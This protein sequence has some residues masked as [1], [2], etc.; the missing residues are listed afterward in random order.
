MKYSEKRK[1]IN[2]AQILNLLVGLL[3]LLFLVLYAI[4]YSSEYIK[5]IPQLTLTLIPVSVLFVTTIL[6]ALHFYLNSVTLKKEYFDTLLEENKH[7]ADFIETADLPLDLEVASLL[8]WIKYLYVILIPATFFSV[9]YFF[10]VEFIKIKAIYLEDYLGLV[11]VL[12]FVTVLTILFAAFTIGLSKY[13]NMRPL[14]TTANWLFIFAFSIVLVIVNT[15]LLSNHYFFSFLNFSYYLQLGVIGVFALEPLLFIALSFYTSKDRQESIPA[16]ESRLMMLVYNFDNLVST[17][18][19]ALEYQFGYSIS[20]EMLRT[21]FRDKF[22]KFVLLVMGAFLCMSSFVRVEQNEVAVLER[23]GSISGELLTP[24]LHFKYPYP[25]ETVRIL[26]PGVVRELFI[27]AEL[28]E[29]PKIVV[30]QL[31]HYKNMNQF[32]LANKNNYSSRDISSYIS[33]LNAVMGVQYSI[34]TDSASV[35]SYLYDNNNPVETL[36]NISKSAITNIFAHSDTIEVMSNS[37]TKVV[38]ELKQFIEKRVKELNLGIDIHS[39]N[40]FD[41]HPPTG[42]VAEAFQNVIGAQEEKKSLELDAII[43]KYRKIPSAEVKGTSKLLEAK[44]QVYKKQL[45]AKGESIRFK[46]QARLY[47]LSPQYFYISEYLTIFDKYIS[48]VRKIILPA[49]LKSEVIELNL[50]QNK[51]SDLFDIDLNKLNGN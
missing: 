35:F 6:S 7:S 34:K 2:K 48:G 39:V 8:S 16:Y 3:S 29:K 12:S 43:Y 10:P 15:L 11:A 26:R 19:N 17:I 45:I 40:L 25:I 24:G 31:P 21:A 5:T 42:D 30:W 22:L 4:N 51:S 23:F 41:I 37:R 50:K 38:A 1:I 27:G 13:E 14:R 9:T 44:A 28:K 47:D 49:G 33:V 46:Q 18:Q 36:E 32:L 20:K